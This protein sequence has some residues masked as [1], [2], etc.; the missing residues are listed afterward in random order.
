M[1]LAEGS[2]RVG[3]S[4]R[5]SAAGGRGAHGRGGDF[6]LHRPHGKSATEEVWNVDLGLK[7]DAHCPLMVLFALEGRKMFQELP[8]P[9]RYKKY[10]WVDTTRV[11]G[12][13]GEMAKDLSILTMSKT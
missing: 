4:R 11:D 2:R 1:T 13:Q 10:E 5:C 8:T 7:K 6:R 3:G 9:Q 12:F